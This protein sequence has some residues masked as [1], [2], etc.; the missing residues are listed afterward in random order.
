MTT[1]TENKNNGL[2][3]VPAEG[4]ARS[5]RL[6]K[7]GLT[8]GDTNGIGYELIMK[9][10]AESSMM[11]ICVPVVYGSPKIAAYHRKVL[12]MNVNF[13]N[14]ASASEAEEGMLNRMPK[15]AVRPCRLW[16]GLWRT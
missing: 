15:A 10:F 1:D 3:E 16:K 13:H 2:A 4:G 12:D 5:L 6:L 8:H 14:I 9:T 7:V 11:E